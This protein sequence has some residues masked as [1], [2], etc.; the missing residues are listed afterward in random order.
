MLGQVRVAFGNE[1]QG[2]GW[3]SFSP[4][5]WDQPLGT[6]WPREPWTFGAVTGDSYEPSC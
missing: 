6:A 1:P 4:H 3:A 2:C 5:L